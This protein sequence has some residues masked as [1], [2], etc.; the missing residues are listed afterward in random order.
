MQSSSLPDSWHA[1]I[2]LE[3]ILLEPYT[4]SKPEIITIFFT[5]DTTVD[6]TF[7][8]ET[9]IPRLTTHPRFSAHPVRSARGTFRFE[10]HPAPDWTAHLVCE[11]SLP[12]AST[13][14]QKTH[15]DSRLAEIIS[16]PLDLSRPLWQIHLFR[17]WSV[18]RGECKASTLVF[19]V[20]H[21]LSD[22]IGLVKYFLSSVVDKDDRQNPARLLVRSRRSK[23]DTEPRPGCFAWLRDS[24]HDFSRVFIRPLF[25]DPVCVLTCAEMTENN[26]C[27]LAAPEQITVPALKRAAGQLNVTINDLVFAA[28][29]GAVREYLTFSGENP[30]SLRGLN[31]A[32]PFNKHALDE[33]SMSDVSNQ[34]LLIPITL[35]SHLEERMERLL[36][37]SASM[38]QLKRSY[39]PAL[40]AVAMRQLAA[41]PTVLRRKLWHVVGGSVSAL[42][43]NVAGPTENMTIGGKSV[44]EVYFFPPPNVHVGCDIGVFS[45]GGKV[46]LGAAG[47]A[48]RLTHPQKLL[49][50]FI[51]EVLGFFEFAKRTASEAHTCT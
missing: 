37:C 8:H 22:G 35:P 7:L 45:Y 16:T 42:F 32:M 49:N 13:E 50:Y 23:G 36:A 17:N 47:D 12:R 43:S 18:S 26:I 40:A 51:D 31:V 5:V 24:F 14:Q 41:L 38:K 48:N 29:S 19:R 20:H 10:T 4:P 34:L 2:P 30:S 9:V 44:D 28:F 11:P 6:A 27:A 15:F 21:C 25:K 1:V 39:Q 3:Q 46:F 33:F